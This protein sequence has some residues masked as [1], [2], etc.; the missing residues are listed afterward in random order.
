MQ[1]SSLA[2]TPLSTLLYKTDSF[3]VIERPVLHYYKGYSTAKKGRPLSAVSCGTRPMRRGRPHAAAPRPAPRR[4]PPRARPS[5]RREWRGGLVGRSRAARRG[6]APRPLTAGALARGSRRRWPTERASVP[7]DYRGETSTSRPPLLHG[8]ACP[9]V[10]PS[11]RACFL[12]FSFF[13][14]ELELA[15]AAQLLHEVGRSPGQPRPYEFYEDE[16][17][18]PSCCRKS[19]RKAWRCSASRRPASVLMC[20]LILSSFS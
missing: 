20:A 10:A 19:S 3:V 9:A 5:T 2:A 15:L 6:A 18:R 16:T 8:A 14:V 1:R 13:L 7:R 11:S 12:S 17:S 4:Q